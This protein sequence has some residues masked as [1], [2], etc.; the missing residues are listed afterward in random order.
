MDPQEQE[1]RDGRE[2]RFLVQFHFLTCFHLRR[3]WCIQL[4]LSFAAQ[5]GELH[6]A[7]VRVSQ[8]AK[9]S[10]FGFGSFVL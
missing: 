7:I 1:G 3:L 10:V 8:T 4:V 6:C 2:L 5:S 9:L